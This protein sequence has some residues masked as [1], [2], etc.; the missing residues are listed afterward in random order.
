MKNR[1]VWLGVS[2]CVLM[3]VLPAAQAQPRERE[4]YV[5]PPAIERRERPAMA[6]ERRERLQGLR[7]ELRQYGPRPGPRESPEE[8]RPRPV[9]R[10]EMGRFVAPSAQ[11]AGALRRLTPEERRQLRRELRDAYR[12]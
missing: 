10:H 9:E 1:A 8:L 3:G 4:V 6:P 5:R 12:D 2:W 7:E 11:E